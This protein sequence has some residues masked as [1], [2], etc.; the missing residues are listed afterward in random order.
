MPDAKQWQ[1]ARLLALSGMRGKAEQERRATSGFLAVL[2]TV[3]EFH[4]AL[5][6]PLGAPGRGRV[7][8][9]CEVPFTVKDKKVRVDGA[10]QVTLGKRT[11]TLLVEVKTGNSKLTQQQTETYLDVVKQEG[12]D[13]LLTISNQLV[14]VQG[15]HP[16]SVGKAYGNAPLYHLSW[17]RILST[18]VRVRDHIKV[19]D[20]EQAWLLRELIR[21]LADEKS[22]ARSFE[23][24]GPSWTALRRALVQESLQKGDLH[25][26]RVAMSWEHLLQHISLRLASELGRNVEPVLTRQE[27][28]DPAI[29]RKVIADEL[30]EQGSLSGAIA[31]PDAAARLHV[32]ADLKSMM[33]TASVTLDAPKM[34]TPTARLN[35]LLR[36]L[37]SEPD[38]LRVDVAFEHLSVVASERLDVLR[39]DPRPALSKANHPPRAFTVKR[40]RTVGSRRGKRSASFVRNV[41]KLVD[42]FYRE[43]VQN[44]KAWTPPAPKLPERELEELA[45]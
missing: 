27:R 40:T 42:E 12:F 17:E 1:S 28:K 36:Q 9:Y 26:D 18:A 7:E 6:K 29:R 4:R 44:L 41:E 10:I 3:R 19:E 21:Y 2:T 30:V 5:L 34:A 35:W 38:T 24:M 43:V 22:G 31:I 11:W 33:A 39:K 8:A 25:A 20:T 16:V 32:S 14:S 23:D 37:K 13:G 45:Q 15:H